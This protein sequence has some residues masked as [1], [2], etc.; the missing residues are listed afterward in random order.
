MAAPWKQH[1]GRRLTDWLSV[2]AVAL[3]V[4]A[5]AVASRPTSLHAGTVRSSVHE[6]KASSSSSDVDQRT[7]VGNRKFGPFYSGCSSSEFLR[8]FK[9]IKVNKDGLA[10]L[11]P[12]NQSFALEDFEFS[13][14]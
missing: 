5:L 6:S 7:F 11:V 1:G 10:A 9:D 13:F 12:D 14:D 4:L 8:N 3:S 2:V